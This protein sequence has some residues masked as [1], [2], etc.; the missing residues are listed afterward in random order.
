MVGIPSR[1]ALA[2]S[3]CSGA[4]EFHKKHADATL[5]L[6]LFAMFVFHGKMQLVLLSPALPKAV[7]LSPLSLRR[8]VT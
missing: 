8:K 2:L 4:S 1:I 6:P 3:Q 7:L 5:K